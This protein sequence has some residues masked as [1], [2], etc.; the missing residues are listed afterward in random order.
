V[1]EGSDQ[2]K[3][4]PA[5]PRKREKVREQ[6][7]VAQSREIPSAVVLAVAMMVFTMGAD[8]HWQR[9]MDLFLYPFTLI[10]QIE[11]DTETLRPVTVEIVFRMFLFMAPLMLAVLVMGVTSNVVQVGILYAREAM[12]P[13]IGRLNP[14]SGAKNMLSVKS[15][16]EAIKNLFKVL[17]V[18]VVVWTVMDDRF[19]ELLGMNRLDARDIFAY[20]MYLM[21]QIMLRTTILLVVLGILDY[22]FQRWQWERRNRMTKDEV[23]DEYKQMEGDPKIKARI[24]SIQREIAMRRMMAEV[25]KADVVITN[26]THVAVALRYERAAYAAPRVVAKG[27]GVIAAKIREIASQHGVPILE[28]PALARELYRLVKLEQEIPRA[29]YQAVAEILAYIFNLREKRSG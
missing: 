5:T 18:S 15:L 12:T 16:G 22:A 10:G 27:R 14:I 19:E 23:K 1:A 29:L 11:L 4:E 6:G 9:L 3:T 17:I 25:P 20:L 21:Y 28:R 8:W 26:P 24:R 2:E 7:N 13:Q